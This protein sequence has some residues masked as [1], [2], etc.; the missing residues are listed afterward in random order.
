MYTS[1]KSRVRNCN[2]DSEYFK[3]TVG[4]RQCEVMTPIMFSMFIN[5][6]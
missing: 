5:D 2:N 3:C 6:L 4:L 1:L